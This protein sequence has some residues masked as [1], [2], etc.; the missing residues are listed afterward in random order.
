MTETSDSSEYRSDVNQSELDFSP[1]GVI[2]T[3]RFYA[4]PD[5]I[6]HLRRMF[7]Q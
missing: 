2:T 6:L 3:S 1:E 5:L 4:S 7:C